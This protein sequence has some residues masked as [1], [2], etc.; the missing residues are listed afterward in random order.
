MDAA[1]RAVGR[2]DELRVGGDVD[3]RGPEVVDLRPAEDAVD[4]GVGVEDE[5]LRSAAREEP[6]TEAGFGEVAPLQRPPN[7]SRVGVGEH[8]GLGEP[9][10]VDRL[11]PHGL[12]PERVIGP[13][14]E[15]AV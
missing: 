4:E 1:A 3:G 7:E 2:E 10:R 8:R 5:A 9:P 12:G 6:E 14:R 11:E 13:A 15:I